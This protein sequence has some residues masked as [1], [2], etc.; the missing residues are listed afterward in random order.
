[1]DHVM[2]PPRGDASAPGAPSAGRRTPG[3]PAPG[4]PPELLRPAEGITLRRRSPAQ[5][6][7]LN[8]A[9]RANLEHLRPWMEWAAEAPT[10][11]RTVALAV[12]GVA[13]WDAGTDFIYLAAL[14]AEPDRVIGSFG[15]HRR[16]GPDALEIGYW[17]SAEHGRRGIATAAARSVTAAA[18]ALPGIR[19]VE[20]HCDPANTASGA[21][22][23]RLG[24][25]LDR[26]VDAPVRAP[27]ETGRKQVWIRERRPPGPCAVW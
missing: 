10:P 17:V 19:R 26:V 15:L 1:M 24:F 16:I 2:P 13:A 5:A 27:G 23:R 9:V 22:A 18:L 4:R 6:T 3:T 20:L 11:A 7:A 12:A 21:V 25:R 8:A 14:D